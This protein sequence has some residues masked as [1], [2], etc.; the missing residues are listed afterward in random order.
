[1]W[2]LAASLIAWATK[3]AGYLVPQRW[4]ES[5]GFTRVSGALTI[6][7]LTALVTANT[8]ASGQALSLDSR[9]IAL[10]VAAIGLRARLPFLV[11]VILGA[12]SAALARLA[13]LP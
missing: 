1:M 3:M 8:V 12:A 7:L 4:L 5:P 9:I 10:L 11:V 2:I 13:G 6:G